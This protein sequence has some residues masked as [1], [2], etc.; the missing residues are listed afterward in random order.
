[1]PIHKFILISLNI[2]NIKI[3]KTVKYQMKY[4]CLLDVNQWARDHLHYD[5]T[6]RC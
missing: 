3:T 4:Y 6:L 5:T 2:W 1:M